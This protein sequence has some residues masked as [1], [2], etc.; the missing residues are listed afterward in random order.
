MTSSNEFFERLKD[1]TSTVI[2]Y[3]VKLMTNYEGW[4]DSI[5][6]RGKNLKVSIINTESPKERNLKISDERGLTITIP[7]E[8]V[9]IINQFHNESGVYIEI[10]F[11]V[12]EGFARLNR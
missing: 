2:P 1:I 11:F 4:E 6:M 3:E 9:E 7:F 10:Y 12:Y 5:E 8:G